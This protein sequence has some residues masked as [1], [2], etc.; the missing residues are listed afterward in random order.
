MTEAVLLAERIQVIERGY[1]FLL[2]YAAQGCR[3][4][5]EDAGEGFVLSL[6]WEEAI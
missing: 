5:D 4:E 6:V 2:A 1:E 3:R